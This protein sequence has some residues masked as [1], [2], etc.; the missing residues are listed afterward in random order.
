MVWHNGL[1]SKLEKVEV[2]CCMANFIHS[3]LEN[4]SLSVLVGNQL[5]ERYSL[6]NGTPQ[7]S[8]ISPTLFNIMID[9]LFEHVSDKRIN[10]SKFADDGAIWVAHRELSTIRTLLQETLN[11]V[12]TW[13]DKWGFTIS[14]EKT[15]GVLFRRK[16]V[17]SDT[18]RLTVRGKRVKFEKSAKFLGVTFD[19]YLT[20]SKHA[21][22]LY[23]RCQ[24]DLNAMRAIRGSSWGANRKTLL[25]LYRS[26]IRSKLE[27]GCEAFHNASKTTLMRLESIQY[28]AL[29]IATGAGRDWRATAENQ[30]RTAH[31]QLLE[32]M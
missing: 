9:D 18:P 25:T 17:N 7:G 12:S 23:A 22:N 15:I 30:E 14:P 21:D 20:W 26:L 16:G 31:P 6:D 28:Q 13:C 24:K 5:S 8:V 3:L 10:T 1:L 2:K 27:Y 19:Q 11:G 4:R 29:K 32:Q